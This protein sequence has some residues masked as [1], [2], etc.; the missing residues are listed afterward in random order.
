MGEFRFEKNHQLGAGRAILCSAK[1][2][3]IDANFPGNFFRLATLRSHRVR[4]PR[5]VHV[6]KHPALFRELGDRGDFI[7]LVNRAALRCLRN[8]DHARLVCV[9]FRLTRNRSF[10]LF[11]VD[12]AM[13]A[14]AW[15]LRTSIPRPFRG[16][17]IFA[18]LLAVPLSLLA[19]RFRRTWIDQ[20][21]TAFL[22]VAYA[23]P[24]FWVAILFVFALSIRLRWLPPPA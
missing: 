3:N 23:T 13:V 17:G 2:K 24:T 8:A 9:H 14:L 18:L 4:E 15:L 16:L 7:A 19:V 10:N 12:L 21:A 11:K 5:A 20:A 22:A 1:T 6:Q